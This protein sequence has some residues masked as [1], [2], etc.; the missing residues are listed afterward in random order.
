M[1]NTQR[2]RDRLE[3]W[4]RSLALCWCCKMTVHTFQTNAIWY[5]YI[6]HQTLVTMNINHGNLYEK[7]LLILFSN[8]FFLSNE[9]HINSLYRPSQLLPDAPKTEIFFF[10][11]DGVRSVTC[12]T[13][14]LASKISAVPHISYLPFVK[15]INPNNATTKQCSSLFNELQKKKKKYCWYCVSGTNLR[16][17]IKNANAIAIHVVEKLQA[18]GT[19]VSV[20]RRDEASFLT[21]GPTRCFDV[22][23]VT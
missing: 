1:L 19:A 11:F 13:S 14:T 3:K 2:E 12:V 6:V 8:N 9:C 21:K 18:H 17:D 7:E 5:F 20:F 22:H 10:F 23:V 4:K 16:V 15:H